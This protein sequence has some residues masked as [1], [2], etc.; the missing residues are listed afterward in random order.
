MFISAY[1]QILT[2][3]DWNLVMY[4]GMRG[5]GHKAAAIYFL[6]LMTIGY[7]VLL[8]LLV[9]ILVEGFTTPMVR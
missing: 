3:E 7:Y 4:D 9:A 5:T 2:Q 1:L 6:A 8:N